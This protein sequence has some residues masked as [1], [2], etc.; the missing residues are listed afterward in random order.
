MPRG[1]ERK[2]DTDDSM[3]TSSSFVTAIMEKQREEEEEEEEEQD[4]Q[5]CGICIERMNTLSFIQP[6]VAEADREDVL[7]L[8]DPT[9]MRLK[10]GH[11]FHF[12]CQAPAMRL[13]KFCSL[14][15][16]EVKHFE[17]GTIRQ[18]RMGDE[19]WEFSPTS[20]TT[21]GVGEQ[22]NQIMQSNQ[23]LENALAS[24]NGTNVELQSCRAKMNEA[25]GV[26]RKVANDLKKTR[27]K[28]LRESLRTFRVE[29]KNKFDESHLRIKNLLR[30]NKNLEDS[31]LR[32][33]GFTARQIQ[34]YFS[35]DPRHD[36]N[37]LVS[38]GAVG[39]DPA[40]HRFWYR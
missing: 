3:S 25:L 29:H 27:A 20:E 5:E 36:L 24:E 9:C 23:D 40:R 14:C 2:Y 12:S 6:K 22:I 35:S 15:R 1:Q 4:E 33:R 21:E 8:E 13:G 37:E 38:N 16:D 39:G 19:V 10:C 18:I 31:I 11:A 28:Y 26:H 32:R 17:A 34:D 7:D 30:I